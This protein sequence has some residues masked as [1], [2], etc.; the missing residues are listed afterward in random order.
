VHE[1]GKQQEGAQQNQQHENSQNLLHLFAIVRRRVYIPSS[2]LD[3]NQAA[4]PDGVYITNIAYDIDISMPCLSYKCSIDG[5]ALFLLYRSATAWVF[6]T[7]LCDRA[8]MTSRA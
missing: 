3:L 2:C 6:E 4:R 5:K 7:G 8:W 1:A